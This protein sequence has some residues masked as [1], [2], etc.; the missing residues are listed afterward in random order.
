MHL[1]ASVCVYVFVTKKL[2]FSAVLFEKILLSVYVLYYSGPSIIHTP[3]VTADSSG[4]WII[5]IVG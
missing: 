1:V 4:V 5:E 2:T 3:L